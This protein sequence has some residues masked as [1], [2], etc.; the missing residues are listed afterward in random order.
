MR[1]KATVSSMH[2]FKT[3]DTDTQQWDSRTSAVASDV[4]QDDT[5]SS[6]VSPETAAESLSPTAI[7][8]ITKLR[9]QLESKQ[10]RI[11]YLEKQ[12][13]DLQ[14][15]RNFLRAQ[16]ENL[17][18]SA[19]QSEA[20]GVQYVIHRYKQVLST[21]NKKKSMSGAFRH[22]GIDRNTIANTAPIAELHL[23]AKEMLGVVG[24]FNPREETLVKYAQKC[25]NLIESDENLSRKIELMKATG[26]LLP[27]TAK[28]PKMH[29]MM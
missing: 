21:F 6:V 29:C 14:Q 24:L 18:R 12:V 23:A 5:S 13:E 22:Y 10:E 7:L 26:E 25:A 8:T 19:K 28:K 27:I 20:T 3:E 2:R 16:I 11:N 4:E 17:T 1:K 9:C 15:D